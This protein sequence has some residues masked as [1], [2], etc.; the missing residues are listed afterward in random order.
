M[1]RP[2]HIFASLTHNS[3]SINF[4]YEFTSAWRERERKNSIKFRDNKFLSEISKLVPCCTPTNKTS[5]RVEGDFRGSHFL[6]RY[7]T[8]NEFFMKIYF[9]PCAEMLFALSQIETKLIFDLRA[10]FRRI[11]ACLKASYQWYCSKKK[12]LKTI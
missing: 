6:R 9:M 5:F 7:F 3:K 11:I 4:K 10:I 8:I 2:I 1:S 12:G